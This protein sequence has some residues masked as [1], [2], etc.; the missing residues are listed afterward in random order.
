MLRSFRVENHKSLRDAE[1]LLISAHDR[2]RPVTAIFG[3]NASGKSNLVDGLRWMQHAIRCSFTS[4]E[5]GQGVPRQPF[6]LAPEREDAHSLFAVDLLIN[7]VRHVY[8][9]TANDARILKEWLHVYPHGRKSVVFERDSG[10]WR[11]GSTATRAKAA[12]LSGLTRGSALLL[13]VAGR[14]ELPEVEAVH[15]WFQK[16]LMFTEPSATF[17]QRPVVEFLERS[18]T[19][20]RTMVDLLRAS[21]LGLSDIQVDR[22]GPVLRL[23]FL[24]NDDHPPTEVGD[25]SRGTLAWLRLLVCVLTAL[26]DGGVLCVDEIGSSVHPRLTARLIELFRSYKTNPQDAQLV[27][28][29]HD[30]SLLGTSFGQ[31]ILSY[32]EVWFVEKP[33]DGRSLVTPAVGPQSLVD[34]LA[35]AGRE[36]IDA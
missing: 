26:A 25:Q 3:A 33:S 30:A 18:A 12:V 28:T 2:S 32:D 15:S 8:G 21:D 31:D 16:S 13:S 1:L 17:D 10:E 35:T 14:A 22:T 7:E 34:H 23:R 29:T 9:F 5:P 24:H 4:W 20:H 27:F 36:S 11:F 19:A 6:R